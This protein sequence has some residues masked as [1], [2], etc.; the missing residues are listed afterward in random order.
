MENKKKKYNLGVFLFRSSDGGMKDSG[1]IVSTLAWLWES[2]TIEVDKV[3]C[4]AY[5]Q[6]DSKDINS[7]IE[8]VNEGGSQS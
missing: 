6:V 5:L 3:K 1:V 2:A 4:R 7:G 8:L